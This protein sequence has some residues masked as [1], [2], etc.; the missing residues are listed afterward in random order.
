M[1]DWVEVMHE[2]GK[3]GDIIAVHV[4]DAE[5]EEFKLTKK[6]YCDH[7]GITQKQYKKDVVIP[8]QEMMAKESDS[9]S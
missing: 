8:F 7:V 5:G 6:E 4:K 9:N 3:D 2:H 1:A